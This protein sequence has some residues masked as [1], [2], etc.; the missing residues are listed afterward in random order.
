MPISKLQAISSP[1]FSIG[2]RLIH[3]FLAPGYLDAV[4]IFVSR[5]ERVALGEL[6]RLRRLRPE[7]R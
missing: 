6:R 4:K 5:F 1:T 3:Y 2:V 7:S